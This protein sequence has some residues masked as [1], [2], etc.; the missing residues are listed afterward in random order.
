VGVLDA[1]GSILEAI[2]DGEEEFG[3]DAGPQVLRLGESDS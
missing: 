3:Q 2:T 1:V